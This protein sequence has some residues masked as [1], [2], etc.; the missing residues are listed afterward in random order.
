MNLQKNYL[1][2]LL[3]SERGIEPIVIK[4]VNQFLSFKLGID[5]FLDILSSLGGSTSLDFFESLQDFNDEI[6]SHIS[7][8]MIQKS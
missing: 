3:D 6:F 4:K 1:L 2:P 7:D 5:Q 8:S